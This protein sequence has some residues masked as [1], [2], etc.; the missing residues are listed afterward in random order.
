[1]DM[2]MSAPKEVCC[3]GCVFLYAEL[4]SVP[5]LRDH[6][7][8]DGGDSCAAPEGEDLATL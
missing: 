1:M 7:R 4:W 5:G 3:G 2:D 6:S 8:A